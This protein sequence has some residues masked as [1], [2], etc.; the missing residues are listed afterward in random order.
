MNIYP[1]SEYSQQWS[2]MNIYLKVNIH[3]NEVLW[4]FTPKVNIHNNEVLWIYGD[5]RQDNLS[6]LKLVSR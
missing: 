5:H 4:I 1:Q 2:V 3:N 6:W